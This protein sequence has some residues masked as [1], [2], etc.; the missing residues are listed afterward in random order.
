MKLR[1]N[2][3]V[4]GLTLMTTIVTGCNLDDKLKEPETPDYPGAFNLTRAEQEM[5]NNSNEFAFNLFKQI[6]DSRS[7]DESK[8]TES[9]IISPISITYALGM[10][11]N[12]AAGETQKQI[13]KVLGFGNTGAAGINDF[14]SK[15]LKSAPAL[16]SLTKVMIANN[17]YVNKNYVLLPEFKKI[18]GTYYNAY[19]ETRDFHDG[20]TM[21]VINKWASDHT[22]KMIKKVLDESSFDPDAVSYLLNAIY[23]KGEWTK[24]FDKQYTVEEDFRHF[25]NN[26]ATTTCPMMHMTTELEYADVDGYQV[27]RLPYGNKSFQM[28]ILLP[29]VY[30]FCYDA[31]IPNLKDP[32]FI[33][34]LPSATTWSQ[35]NK[36]ISSYLVDLK[37]PR[38]ETNTDIDLPQIMSDLGMPDAFNPDKA[39]FSK[40]CNTSPYIGL[41]KQVARIKLDEEGTEAA[42]VTVIG[43]KNTM[44]SEEPKMVFF[45]ANHPFIYIISEK[46]SNAIFFIGQYT[47]Y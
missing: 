45:H 47:G 16:D 21:D 18:A 6:I 9:I 26:S 11:N 5:V 14:C 19:P 28:T 12:G 4:I 33:L 10:L 36:E 35:I 41:M 42:A 22:E 8:R 37:L 7:A 3:A 44:V 23:F 17:I 25:G 29:D 30:R 2:W 15:M 40:F 31:P 34:P 1:N 27:L 46:S 13:N 39:D 38:F 20:Q 32:L 43:I 24:K